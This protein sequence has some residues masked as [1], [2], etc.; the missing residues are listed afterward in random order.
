MLDTVRNQDREVAPELVKRP[1]KSGF[2][3]RYLTSLK[4]RSYRYAVLDPSR[5]NDVVRFLTIGNYAATTLRMAYEAHAEFIRQLNRGEV[6]N[7]KQNESVPGQLAALRDQEPTVG[8]L[9]EE[10]P[11]HYV[12]RERKRPAEADRTIELNILMASVVLTLAG[13]GLILGRAT[14]SL[15]ITEAPLLRFR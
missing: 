5:K 12:Y 7:L 4:P 15:L 10:F 13:Y 2:T 8:E 9:A 1:R 3:E 14:A 6:P 11:K